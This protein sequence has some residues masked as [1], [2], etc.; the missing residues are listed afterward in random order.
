MQAIESR[1]KR[2]FSA[3]LNVSI[4]AGM[5][6]SFRPQSDRQEKQM[7]RK[8]SA[9]LWRP[10]SVASV[11]LGALAMASV[12]NA[13]QCPADKMGTDVTK[14]GTMA[15]K[16]VTDKV[17]ASIDLA[18]EPAQIQDRQL[19]L[20]RLVIEP[21]GVVPWHSH[22]DR[23]AIIYIVEGEIVEH[24]SNCAVPIL[25]KA[26]EVAPETHATSHWWQNNGTKTV[27]LLSADILHDQD[28][29]N[30]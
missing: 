4:M 28:D 3:D 17:L 5:L 11:M 21:G 16:D 15:A 8:S 20:R 23:P 10:M 26:G 2:H 6:R 18:K 25:H 7:S 30:M 27:V 13:G 1:A 9:A 24:A 22:G 29:K 12:A 19:R 14:P